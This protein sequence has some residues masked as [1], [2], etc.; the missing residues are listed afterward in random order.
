MGESEV[1]SD[2]SK[3]NFGFKNFEICERRERKEAVS[4][5]ERGRRK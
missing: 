2:E 4:L 5:R 3:N 1:I